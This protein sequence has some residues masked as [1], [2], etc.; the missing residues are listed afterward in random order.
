MVDISR[1]L[2]QEVLGDLTFG[3][4]RTTIGGN[5]GTYLFPPRRLLL[6]S[7]FLSVRGPLFQGLVLTKCSPLFAEEGFILLL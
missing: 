6:L 1:I 4:S 3:G 2:D 7:P 5:H